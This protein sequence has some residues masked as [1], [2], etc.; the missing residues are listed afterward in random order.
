[1]VYRVQ[2]L[3]SFTVAEPGKAIT[4]MVCGKVVVRAELDP[5]PEL[6]VILDACVEHRRGCPDIRTK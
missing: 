6:A 5:P 2:D 4:C 1:V 3:M